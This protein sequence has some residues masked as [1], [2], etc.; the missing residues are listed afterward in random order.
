MVSLAEVV[1]LRA[2]SREQQN[3]KASDDGA[4]NEDYD[5]ESGSPSSFLSWH[6]PEESSLSAEPGPPNAGSTVEDPSDSGPAAQTALAEVE[7]EDAG[8]DMKYCLCQNVSYGVMVL[9]ENHE[10]PYEW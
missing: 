2:E 6:L 4:D 7:D 5:S 10:C 1:H 9:C 8:D 3:V